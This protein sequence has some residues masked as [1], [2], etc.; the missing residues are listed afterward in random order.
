[1]DITTS[2]PALFHS[3]ASAIHFN[4]SC[5]TLT[6]PPHDSFN[7]LGISIMHTITNPAQFPNKAIGRHGPAATTASGMD[8]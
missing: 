5:P 1:M 7:G 3:L 4:F 8:R 2:L 6:H